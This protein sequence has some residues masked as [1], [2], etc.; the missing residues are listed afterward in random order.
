ML[1]T[2]CQKF[3]IGID[4]AMKCAAWASNPVNKYDESGHKTLAPWK[5]EGFPPID[6]PQ[7]DFT[8]NPAYQYA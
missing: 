7:S 1:G 4:L 6:S 3:N 2:L 8:L 5:P